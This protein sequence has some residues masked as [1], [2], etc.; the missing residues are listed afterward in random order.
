MASPM[1]IRSQNARKVYV[2]EMEDKIWGIRNE[3]VG[4]KNVSMEKKEK[5]TKKSM[6]ILGELDAIG[7]VVSATE[8]MMDVL[9]FQWKF[10]LKGVMKVTDFRN[11]FD[12]VCKRITDYRIPEWLQVQVSQFKQDFENLMANFIL[13]E[14]FNQELKLNEKARLLVLLEL[15]DWIKKCGIFHYL[16]MPLLRQETFLPSTLGMKVGKY[17]LLPTKPKTK[18][19]Y[20]QMIKM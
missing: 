16:R 5:I 7:N 11:D 10:V 1:F 17:N 14:K 15:K 19:E 2:D 8:V 3:M 13:C 18:N 6:K 20:I 4:M 9:K 12:N